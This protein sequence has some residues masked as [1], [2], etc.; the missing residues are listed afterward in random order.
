MV[1][2]DPEDLAA[3]A[4]DPDDVPDAVRDHVRSCSSCQSRRTELARLADGLRKAGQDGPLVAPAPD[5]R[6]RV[7][8]EAAA[9]PTAGTAP[10]AETPGQATVVPLGQ[11]RARRR[12]VP[13]WAAGLAAAVTLVAGVGIGRVLADSEATPGS[14]DV[15]ASADLTSLEGAD[16]R[17]RARAVRTTDGDGEQGEAI[18]LRVSAEELGG[19]DGIH[20][21]WLINVDGTRMVS[22]GLLAAGDDGEFE[23]PAGLL[24]EGYRIVDISVEP[25]DGDPTHSGVSLARGELV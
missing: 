1:H 6:R 19:Q 11:A 17:G 18:T 7:L 10:T 20:E 21:V 16:P 24:E 15:V 25:T 14:V 9:E 2:A 8:A 3:L 22:V 13:V 23:V 4:V 5:V 12:G